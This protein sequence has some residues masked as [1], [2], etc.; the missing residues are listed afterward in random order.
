[1]TTIEVVLLISGALIFTFSFIIPDKEAGGK[2]KRGEADYAKEVGDRIGKVL[3]QSSDEIRRRIRDITDEQADAAKYKTERDLERISN[4][5]IMAVNEYSKTVID[6]IENNHKEVM[7]LYDMLN[8]KSSDIKDTIRKAENNRHKENIGDDAAFSQPHEPFSLP[9]HLIP[10][11]ASKN[12]KKRLFAEKE[13]TASIAKARLMAMNNRRNYSD[14]DELLNV[15][16]GSEDEGF[17]DPKTVMMEYGDFDYDLSGENPV[18]YSDEILENGQAEP[19]TEAVEEEPVQEL[20]ENYEELDEI[21]GIG[22]RIEAETLS[23][24]N[25][26]IID[27]PS[28]REIDEEVES[29]EN[30]IEPLAVQNEPKDRPLF[31]DIVEV[32][33]ATPIEKAA[34]PEKELNQGEILFGP[35]EETEKNAKVEEPKVLTEEEDRNKLEELLKPVISSGFEEKEESFKEPLVVE[36]ALTKPQISSDVEKKEKSP[37]KPLFSHELDTRNEIKLPQP[38][39][40]DFAKEKIEVPIIE[41]IEKPK[42]IKAPLE[43][44]LDEKANDSGGAHELPK[45]PLK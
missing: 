40:V 7:F 26:E 16:D 32:K 45:K 38:S 21:F 17:L 14:E 12:R 35:F 8:N 42:D 36:E 43:K 22:E 25:N 6:E 39:S 19:G 31:E 30:G 5:K 24:I 10:S 27:S 3:D 34:E 41:H 1:M 11:S 28:V 23:R 15:Q 29:A 9:S 37:V 4:E 44:V 13:T 18:Q 20:P 33:Q 2:N